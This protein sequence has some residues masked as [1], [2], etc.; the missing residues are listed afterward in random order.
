MHRVGSVGRLADSSGTSLQLLGRFAAKT[1]G[2]CCVV[3]G[4]AAVDPPLVVVEILY[5]EHPQQPQFVT[6]RSPQVNGT[7]SFTRSG[8]WV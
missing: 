2:L 4:L 3:F 7:Y 6:Q 1:V 5:G 8:V